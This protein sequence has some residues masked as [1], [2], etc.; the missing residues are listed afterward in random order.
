MGRELRRVP[1]DFD[2]PLKK[3][4]KGYLITNASKEDFEEFPVKSCRECEDKFE[5]RDDF[6]L[7]EKTSYCVFYNSKW[8]NKWYEEPPKGDG[9]QLWETTSEGS[10]ITPVFKTLDELCEY[11]ETNCS[12]FSDFKASKEQWKRMLSKGLVYAKRKNFIFV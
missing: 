1:L 12:T 2:A 9:Y 8:R 6:C 10:P 3:G 7:E 11:A 5:D 4:W